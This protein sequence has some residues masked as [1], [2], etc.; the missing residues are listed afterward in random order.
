M[1]QV[2]VRFTL[3]YAN[4]KSEIHENKFEQYVKIAL[5]IERRTFSLHYRKRDVCTKLNKAHSNNYIRQLGMEGKL[6]TTMVTYH[7]YVSYYSVCLLH[8]LLD[9]YMCL[10]L[11]SLTTIIFFV[12]KFKLKL[13]YISINF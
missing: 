11:Q 10:F 8:K 12:L 1:I 6:V 4:H 3:L 7:H 9:G 13:M 5:V 2:N